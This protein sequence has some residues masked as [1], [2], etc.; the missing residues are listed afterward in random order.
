[1]HLK[2]LILVHLPG[3]YVLKLLKR[4][5]SKLIFHGAKQFRSKTFLR[6][7]FRLLDLF[8]HFF[9]ALYQHN[10]QTVFN[11][12]LSRR[13]LLMLLLIYRR[14]KQMKTEKTKICCN[15]VGK[16]IAFFLL[17]PFSLRPCDF[18]RPF[19]LRF[20]CCVSIFIFFSHSDW[21]LFFDF[22]RELNFFQLPSQLTRNFA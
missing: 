12:N 20:Y 1:M 3:I 17:S 5:D 10:K 14:R 19:F 13:Q 22:E 2:A 16:K 6:E 9:F 7:K 15:F 11:M 21:F 8:Q 4:V 18:C